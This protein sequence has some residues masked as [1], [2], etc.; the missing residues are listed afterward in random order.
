MNLRVDLILPTEYRSG[1]RITL[2]GVTRILTIILPIIVVLL[3]SLVFTKFRTLR[4]DVQRQEAQWLKMEPQYKTALNLWQDTIRRNG[5][6]SEIQGWHAAR[7]EWHKQLKALQAAVPPQIQ[8]TSL[9][10]DDLIQVVSNKTVRVFKMQIKGRASGQNPE[11][12][13][14]ALRSELTRNPVF[15]PVVK[16][17]EVPPGSF[18]QDPSPNAAKS[19]RVFEIVCEYAPMG[20]E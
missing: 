11:D 10:V 8:L 17:A 4:S 2:S 1:S 20:F 6:L 13:V 3:L 16:S 7:V 19:D 14:A 9:R 15:A 5:V 12:R 18:G